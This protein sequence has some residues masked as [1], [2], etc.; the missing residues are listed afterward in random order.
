[1]SKSRTGRGVRVLALRTFD[2]R[3]EDGHDEQ[4]EGNSRK[5]YGGDEP[6]LSE[7]K[8]AVEQAESA[9][10]D[11]GSARCSRCLTR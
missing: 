8:G 4:E 11:E 1:M 5:D 9:R 6:R 7:K 10:D 3:G 2:G